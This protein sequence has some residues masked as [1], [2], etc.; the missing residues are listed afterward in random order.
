MELRY[1]INIPYYLLQS[2]LYLQYHFV[3]SRVIY[4][5]PLAEHL[6]LFSHC[7]LFTEIVALC[8]R[9]KMLTVRCFT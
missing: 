8:N 7:L 6:V 2:V 1:I 3:L 5:L 9:N 4:M